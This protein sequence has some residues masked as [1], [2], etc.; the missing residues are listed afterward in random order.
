MTPKEKKT[1]L[2]KLITNVNNCTNINEQ[3]DENNKLTDK[4]MGYFG[5]ESFDNLDGK[6]KQICLMMTSLFNNQTMTN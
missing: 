1:N 3:L 2:F 6:Q 5:V 4:C